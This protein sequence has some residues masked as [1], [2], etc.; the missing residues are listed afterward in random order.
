MCELGL[1]LQDAPGGRVELSVAPP[2]II[3]RI[4]LLFIKLSPV[5]VSE[6]LLDNVPDEFLVFIHSLVLCSTG[7]RL[8]H[9]FNLLDPEP[10][11]ERPKAG[12]T[13]NNLKPQIWVSGVNFLAAGSRHTT[14]LL[15][16]SSPVP[17]V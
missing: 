10:T 2:F 5:T 3:V 6:S 4:C 13:C 1:I 7:L 16:I 11:H 14:Q 12:T 9:I 8:S 17:L 15:R